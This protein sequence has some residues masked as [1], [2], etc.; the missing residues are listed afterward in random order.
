MQKLIQKKS[1]VHYPRLD[2]ILMIEETL[3][4]S[5]DYLL[6]SELVRKLPKKVMY[7][8]LKLVLDYLEKSNKITYDSDKRI[9][10]IAADNPKLKTLL[11]TSV[12]VR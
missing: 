11:K 10:W 2:T 9:I 7:Q 1:S 8:T 6:K 5:N 4:K 3:K 12:H